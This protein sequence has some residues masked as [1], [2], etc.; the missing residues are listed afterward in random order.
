MF[1]GA[2]GAVLFSIA[3]AAPGVAGAA[4]AKDAINGV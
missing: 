4:S 2:A 3:V 1:A